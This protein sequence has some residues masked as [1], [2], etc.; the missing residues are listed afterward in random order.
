MW[1]SIVISQSIGDRAISVTC[2]T[3]FVQWDKGSCKYIAIN[4]VSYNCIGQ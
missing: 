1:Q 3:W 4:T 2:A